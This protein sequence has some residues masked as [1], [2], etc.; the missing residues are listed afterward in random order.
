M[1]FTVSQ[2]Q[3]LVVALLGGVVFLVA[4][5]VGFWAW[6]LTVTRVRDEGQ[7]LEF[8]DGL[9]EGNRPVPLF[10]ALLA[11]VIV[12]WG[13]LYVLAVAGGGLHVQ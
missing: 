3:Y 9:R 13:I 8:N 7:P 4:V 11:A 2:T 12:L 10:V 1:Y 6:R 5:A